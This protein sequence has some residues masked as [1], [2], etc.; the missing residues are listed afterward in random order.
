ML[1]MHGLL[2]AFIE[3]SPWANARIGTNKQITNSEHV[4]HCIDVSQTVQIR[5][6][7]E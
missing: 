7:M 6:A 2:T 5:T 4:M 1:S 3:I